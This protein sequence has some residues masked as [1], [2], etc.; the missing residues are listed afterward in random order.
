MNSAPPQSQ[1]WL[2]QRA[3]VTIL[4]SGIGLGVYIPALLIQRQLAGLGIAAEVEVLEGHYTADSLHRHIAHREAC[5]K[6]FA[7]AQMAHRMARPVLDNLDPVRIDTLLDGWAAE[8]RSDFIVWSG[9]WLPLLEDYR[10][11]VPGLPVRRDLC[12]IDAEISAS[13][14]VHRA[15]EGD[16]AEI[17]LWNAADMALHH[18]IPVTPE[19]PIPFVERGNRLVVHGGGWG[20]GTYIDTLPALARA[21]HALDIVVHDPAERQWFGPD[22]RCW[23]VDPAWEPWQRGADG[24]LTFPPVGAVARDG[25]VSYSQNKDFHGF[26]RVIREARAVVSKPGGCT[27]IDS[28]DAATPVVLLDAYGYAEQANGAV[29]E[30]LGFGIPFAGWAEG[31]FDPA[32]LERAHAALTARGRS[33]GGYPAAYAARLAA[34]EAA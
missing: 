32:A 16:G 9:F 5:R 31:G 18:E 19:P 3:P 30:R 20:L 8:G 7:L 24:R 12:R 17:W 21:G 22:D 13:F 1:P 15:L 23:I 26:H 6:N 29:W 11:R 2:R 25:S 33:P 4:T 27:L 10:R 28:L 14:K 34:G